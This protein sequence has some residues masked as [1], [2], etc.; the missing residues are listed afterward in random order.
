MKE[1]PSSGSDHG[2]TFQPASW[3]TWR[4]IRNFRLCGPTNH[5]AGCS[6][7]AGDN[8]CCISLA[9]NVLS[10]SPSPRHPLTPCRPLT[11]AMGWLEP[12]WKGVILQRD[13]VV[14]W[15]WGGGRK[16]SLSG[17]W[18]WLELLVW[19]LPTH[20]L[21]QWPVQ[22]GQ[23]WRGGRVHRVP[24]HSTGCLPHNR[25]QILSSLS[26]F[27]T[28]SETGWCRTAARG[29]EVKEWDEEEK[30]VEKMCR[31]WMKEE[32]ELLQERRNTSVEGRG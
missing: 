6:C 24:Q 8:Q 27:T 14:S 19:I 13:N 30:T 5:S 25:S 17:V 10:L 18:L 7:P 4:P 11:S 23:R 26:P 12:C 22:G 1:T 16:W 15:G 29:S 9:Q 3:L 20:S 31:S 21:S 32:S 2:M 28:L